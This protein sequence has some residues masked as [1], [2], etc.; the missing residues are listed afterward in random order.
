MASL[1][2]PP[3]GR[4]P[5]S[6]LH[7]LRGATGAMTQ[8]LLACSPWEAQGWLSYSLFPVWNRC[9]I[10]RKAH[11]SCSPQLCLFCL[12]CPCFWSCRTLAMRVLSKIGLNVTPLGT[13]SVTEAGAMYKE[14]SIC[15]LPQ[16]S[17]WQSTFRNHRDIAEQLNSS[18]DETWTCLVW[19]FAK[20]GLGFHRTTHRRYLH[21]LLDMN[22]WLDN[23]FCL[24]GAGTKHQC[25]STCGSRWLACFPPDIKAPNP[26]HI[27]FSDSQKAA[28][29]LSPVK[30]LLL[31]DGTS[32][33]L[34]YSHCIVHFWKLMLWSL[35]P[36][37]ESGGENP[38]KPQHVWLK[39]RWESVVL[40]A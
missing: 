21:T 23:T 5:T 28:E 2:K 33:K 6:L 34:S 31:P 10:S 4:K 20:S 22:A 29:E 30:F 8:L 38:M 15:I 36:K 19:H 24:G 12:S 13:E 18:W 1:A 26:Q 3:D 7:R 25:A 27:S 35:K 37:A 32:S 40:E 17:S 16:A 9:S 39:V 11:C 14:Q